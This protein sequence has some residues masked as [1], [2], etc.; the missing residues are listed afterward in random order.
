MESVEMLADDGGIDVAVA[1]G[2]PGWA[3]GN[4][5][6]GKSARTEGR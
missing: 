1:C 4:A 3:R 5:V 2:C 6:G